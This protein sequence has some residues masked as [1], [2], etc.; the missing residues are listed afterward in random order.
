MVFMRNSVNYN[1]ALS[2]SSNI[3]LFIFSC[4]EHYLKIIEGFDIKLDWLHIGE[5]QCQRIVS[6]LPFLNYL[7]F[8]TFFCLV[9]NPKNCSRVWLETKTVDTYSLSIQTKVTCIMFELYP[10]LQF[11]SDH[12]LKTIQGINLKLQFWQMITRKRHCRRIIALPCPCLI[13]SL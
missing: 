1:S 12:N 3:S 13:V 7:P 4:P 11:S 2:N 8:I 6:E 10:L 9:Q 5:V